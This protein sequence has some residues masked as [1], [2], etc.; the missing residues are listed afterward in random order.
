VTGEIVGAAASSTPTTIFEQA[1][2]MVNNAMDTAV[3]ARLDAVARD[4]AD[5]VGDEPGHRLL[6][7]G[8]EGAATPSSTRSAMRDAGR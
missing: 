4:V 5:D 7:L 1:N 8:Q 6:A 2:A 3:R